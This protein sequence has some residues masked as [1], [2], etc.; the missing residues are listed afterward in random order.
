MHFFNP[1]PAHG[2][3][4]ADPRVCSPTMRPR[5]APPSSSGASARPPS[6]SRTRRALRSIGCSGPD[7]QRGDFRAAGGRRERVG[8]RRGHE[9]RLQSPDRPAGACGPRWVSIRCCRSWRCSS[10]TSGI[11]NT[12]RRRCCAKWS[13]PACSAARAARVFT[14]LL[15]DKGRG[16]DQCDEYQAP[17]AD[18]QF[19]LRELVDHALIARLPGFEDATLELGEAVLEE[20]A[21][22]AAA[23][24]RR[25]IGSAIAKGVRWQRYPGRNRC[26]LE[27]GLRAVRGRAAGMRSPVRANSA[28]RTCRARSRRWSRKCGTAPTWRSRSVRC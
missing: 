15:S 13:R 8:N 9:A 18:M 23:C 12:G 10:A 19:V 7:D 28:D 24:S 17:L 22:F 5:R 14:V 3:G 6:T 21:K 27:G 20:A 1:V 16:G 4:R 25:S 26:R 2:T 11:R